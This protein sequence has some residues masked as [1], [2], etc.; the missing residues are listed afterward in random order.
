MMEVEVL[1]HATKLSPLHDPCSCLCFPISLLASGEGF[2]RSV[3]Q[4]SQLSSWCHSST[5]R[6]SFLPCRRFF[7]SYP[8]CT[9]RSR[10]HLLP[11]E[12]PRALPC[13]SALPFADVLA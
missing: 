6:P 1:P 13:V 4:P 3:V 12:P 5:A 10:E 11:P 9:Q 2:E 7:A 8:M